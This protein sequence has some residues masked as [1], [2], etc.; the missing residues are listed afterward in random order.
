MIKVQEGTA[1]TVLVSGVIGSCNVALLDKLFR[2]I[3]WYLL[4]VRSALENKDDT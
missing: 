1:K 3:A 2:I 4:P